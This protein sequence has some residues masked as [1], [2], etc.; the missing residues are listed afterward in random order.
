MGHDHITET[1]FGNIN[2]IKWVKKK[3]EKRHF[4]TGLFRMC[5]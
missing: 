3:E 1:T 2:Y 5:I 4:S